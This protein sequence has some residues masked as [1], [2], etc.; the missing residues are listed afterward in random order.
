MTEKL[1]LQC[2]K[3]GLQ[4]FVPK[5]KCKKWTCPLCSISGV[6]EELM[7]PSNLHVEKLDIEKIIELKEGFYSQYD[8]INALVCLAEEI[9]DLKDRLR[10]AECRLETVSE[11]CHEITHE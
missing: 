5:T 6:N 2:L 1:L 9:K 10:T 3:C 7:G 4:D 11:N 8:T